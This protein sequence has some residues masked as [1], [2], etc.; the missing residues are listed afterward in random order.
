MPGFTGN[1][2]YKPICLLDANQWPDR[3]G[4]PSATEI[5]K[6]DDQLR[7]S[8]SPYVEEKRAVISEK[9]KGDN[10]LEDVVVPFDIGL[11]LSESE[12]KAKRSVKLPYMAAQTQEGLV[13]I[14]AS[15]KRKVRA[16]GRIIYTPDEADD[17]DDSDPD[18]DLQI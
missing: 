10:P 4:D 17:L 9:T 14:S 13:G 8:C 11:H 12:L 1:I 18:D 6:V 15:G 2:G 16:G 3:I 5:F 7:L